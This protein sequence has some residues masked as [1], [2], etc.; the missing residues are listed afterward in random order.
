MEPQQQV[1]WLALAMGLVFGVAGQRSGF[2]LMSGMRDYLVEHDGRKLRAF[3]VATV[4]ALLGTQALAAAGLIALEQSI[5]LQPSFS[6]LLLPLGG[7]L[8]GYGMVLANGCGARALVLLGTGNLR[9]LLVL[10]CLAISAFAT[11]RGVLAPLRIVLAD[12]TA[13]GPGWATPTLPGGLAALGLGPTLAGA[14]GVL[15]LTGPLLY[16]ALRDR[17]LRTSPRHWLWGAVI[18]ALVPVGW[19][20]TG[21]LGADPFEPARLVSLTFVAPIG[22]TVQYLMIATGMRADFGILVVA[23]VPAGALAAA[24]AT[25][26][27]RWVGFESAQHML[28]SIAGAVLMGI[29]GALALGCSIGQGI[30]GLSTLALGS[31]LAAAGI[32]SGAAL[33]LRGRPV[34]TGR[35]PAL[36][37]PSAP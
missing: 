14:A 3:A 4:V 16:F 15:L 13:F 19:F 26:G 25:G 29:G 5:Y 33:G 37:P 7:F 11:L 32:C 21:Y 10:L 36:S 28:R 8:F 22:D 31:L 35:H 17:A 34:T 27:F 20:V 9:S 30:T 24:V 12:A 2:C 18:G 23:G 1:L 6:W